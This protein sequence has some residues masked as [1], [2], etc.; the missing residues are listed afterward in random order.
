VIVLADPRVVSKS[1]GRELL[2]ALPPARRVA[3]PWARA[4][5]EVRAFY[6]AAPGGRTRE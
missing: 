1:Y 2:D 4:L 5:D 6:R 3:L